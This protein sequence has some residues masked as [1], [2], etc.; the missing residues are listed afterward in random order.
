MPETKVVQLTRFAASYLT[1][2]TAE[3]GAAKR[4]S[5]AREQRDSQN[6][7]GGQGQARYPR[8]NWLILT[9]M[10]QMGST[11]RIVQSREAGFEQRSCSHTLARASF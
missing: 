1:G 4:W 10:P 3:A 7:N 9:H 6:E 2:L 8:K 11:F 5:P